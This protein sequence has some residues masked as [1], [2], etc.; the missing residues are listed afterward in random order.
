MSRAEE[1][2]IW[3]S[4][5]IQTGGNLNASDSS[6]KTFLHKAVAQKDLELC[7]FLL[8]NGADVNARDFYNNT[9]LH[10]SLLYGGTV[11]ICKLLIDNGADLS[12]TNSAKNTVLH[13]AIIQQVNIELLQYIID[14]GADV[15][16]VNQ[17]N[18]TLLHKA[19]RENNAAMVEFLI[20]NDANVDA[21]DN[22]GN[23][24]LYCAADHGSLDAARLL[25]FYGANPSIMN[26]EGH[27]ALHI[28]SYRGDQDMCR[29]LLESGVDVHD[30]GPDWGQVLLDAHHGSHD[31]HFVLLDRSN[32]M[33]YL[34]T[35]FTTREYD[36][37]FNFPV[38][39][40]Y[41][42]YSIYKKHFPDLSPI[43]EFLAF[44]GQNIDANGVYNI[45]VDPIIDQTILNLPVDIIESEVEI[46]S[47]GNGKKFLQDFRQSIWHENVA[48]D[49]SLCSEDD[50][51]G[52]INS[53]KKAIFNN[54]DILNLIMHFVGDYEEM[55]AMDQQLQ[56][57]NVQLMN[58]DN[59]ANGDE[60]L[61]LLG[62]IE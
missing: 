1:F 60:D 37:F 20:I 46:L 7:N 38:Q 27:G 3:L 51:A 26:Q 31:M 41:A 9:V 40:I 5:L 55:A 15:D 13:T 14:N 53:N 30:L 52:S 50:Y 4:R 16:A 18:E 24:L 23:S 28:A 11:E 12:A 10:Y 6:G 56:G 47:P 54:P 17:A 33:Q 2:N 57:Q 62:D 25:I 8:E 35:C 45:N 32:D 42:R 61:D 58:Q 49:S 36:S 39:N 29:F 19:V 48:K 21:L 43:Y 44:L 59:I 22:N 34:N